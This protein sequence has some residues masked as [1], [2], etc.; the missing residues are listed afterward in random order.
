MEERGG[1]PAVVKGTHSDG[2]GILRVDFGSPNDGLERITWDEFFKIFEESDLAFLYQ[3]EKD[4][5]ESRFFKF[6]AREGGDEGVTEEDE[7][8][9]DDDEKDEDEEEGEESDEE[10]EKDGKAEEDEE[11]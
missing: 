8:T 5:A 1:H 7:M 11:A 4:G 10:E 6:V 3:E 9:A 2:S